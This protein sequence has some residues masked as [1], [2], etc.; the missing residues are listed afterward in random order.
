MPTIVIDEGARP[1]PAAVTMGSAFYLEETPGGVV[2]ER[3]F[4]FDSFSAVPNDDFGNTQ[5]FRPET[6]LFSTVTQVGKT[7]AMGPYNGIMDYNATL[8]MMQS[9]LGK[10]A[11]STPTHN[12]IFRMSL[13]TPSAGTFIVSRGAIDT[14]PIAYNATPAAIKTAIENEIGPNSVKLESLGGNSYRIELQ[15]PYNMGLPLEIDGTGLTAGTP[16]MI[17]DAAVNTRR[18]KIL[19]HP[20]RVVQKQTFLW[21]YGPVDS[22]NEAFSLAYAFFDGFSF[23]VNQGEATVSGNIHG[24][25]MVPNQI[26]NSETIDYV[27]DAPMNMSSFQV[28]IGITPEGED[29]VIPICEI[30]S[31]AFGMSGK[32][33]PITDIGCREES[34]NSHVTVAPDSTV[35]LVVPANQTGRNIR[36]Q[37]KKGKPVTIVVESIGE[38]IELGY[39]Y[40]FLAQIPVG[41]TESPR[42]NEAGVSVYSFSGQIQ[43]QGGNYPT[44]WVDT[45]YDF[46]FTA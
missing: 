2:A 18:Y 14:A 17:T 7:K 28:S 8:F 21:K 10:S 25:T 4:W 13:G 41:F 6:S 1:Q 19:V 36:E 32:E 30:K 40:R 20:N 38:E 45:D 22:P 9:A 11:V 26:I 29:G 15:P 37:V 34:Y 5:Q 27:P 31:F 3:P 39:P 44:F 35:T 24:Q 46:N 23:S 16:S 12:G 33:N 43:T 42:N